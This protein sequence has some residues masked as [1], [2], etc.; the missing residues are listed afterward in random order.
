MKRGLTSLFPLCY[1]KG[2]TRGGKEMRIAEGYK[3]L[4]EEPSGDIIAVIDIGDY[5]LDKQI[6]RADIMNQIQEITE[7]AQAETGQ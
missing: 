7:R 5:D 4:I 2:S 3:V 1:T 6:A